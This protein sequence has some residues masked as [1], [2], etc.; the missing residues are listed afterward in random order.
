LRY[1]TS[2]ASYRSLNLEKH[3]ATLLDVVV[4]I[5]TDALVLFSD[6]LNGGGGPKTLFHNKMKENEKWKEIY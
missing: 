6:T 1:S 5:R 4:F 2:F 3:R